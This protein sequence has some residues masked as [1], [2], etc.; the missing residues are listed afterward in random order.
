MT[1]LI[2]NL[3]NENDKTG[4]GFGNHDGDRGLKRGSASGE[5]KNPPDINN[6]N[7]TGNIDKGNPSK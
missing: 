4:Y 1:V 3:D 2:F 5:D 7:D 6:P